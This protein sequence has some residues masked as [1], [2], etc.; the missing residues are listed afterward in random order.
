MLVKVFMSNEIFNINTM[1]EDDFKTETDYDV[2]E[3]NK[4]NDI[5]SVLFFIWNVLFH[6]IPEPCTL[7]DKFVSK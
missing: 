6:S 1:S 2:L 3:I 4:V 7:H 5:Q